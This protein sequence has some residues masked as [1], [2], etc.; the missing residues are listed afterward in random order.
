MNLLRLSLVTFVACFCLTLTGCIG[1]DIQWSGFE[2]G[3]RGGVSA[4]SP[5]GCL[6]RR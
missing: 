2:S 3:F 4:E 1:D 5:A 6:P